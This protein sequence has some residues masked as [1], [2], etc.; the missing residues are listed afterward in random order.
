LKKI[1]IAYILNNS[2]ERRCPRRSRSFY[3]SCGLTPSRTGG[4]S[5]VLTYFV[6]ETRIPYLSRGASRGALDVAAESVTVNLIM[7][8]HSNYGSIMLSFRDMTTE[9]TKTDDRLYMVT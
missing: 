8:F 3:N 1:L 5:N 9:R 4:R 6:F 2:F 7:V